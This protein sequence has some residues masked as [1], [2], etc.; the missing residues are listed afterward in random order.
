MR[1][2]IRKEYFKALLFSLSATTV[3]QKSNTCQHAL[4]FPLARTGSIGLLSTQP[5]DSN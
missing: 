1:V 4:L 3:Y 2:D 5:T